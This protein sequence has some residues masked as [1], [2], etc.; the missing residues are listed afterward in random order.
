MLVRNLSIFYQSSLF[1]SS[2]Q[3]LSSQSLTNYHSSLLHHP[4]STPL[5]PDAHPA[6]PLVNSTLLNH[7]LLNG[8]TTSLKSTQ[9]AR[10]PTTAR[11]R[12]SYTSQQHTRS[13]RYHGQSTYP[14]KYASNGSTYL[15]RRKPGS[16]KHSSYSSSSYSQDSGFTLRHSS[17]SSGSGEGSSL[18][19]KQAKAKI[20]QL[21]KEVKNSSSFFFFPFLLLPH[22]SL[23]LLLLFSSLLLPSPPSPPCCATS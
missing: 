18:E 23:S 22:S 15:S 10:E 1:L 21:E 11:P 19:L 16:E 4:H 3:S 17:G 8:S 12:G 6:P 7:S 14:L 9:S 13:S 2:L 20:R 5:K